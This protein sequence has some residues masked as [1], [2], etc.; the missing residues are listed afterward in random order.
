MNPVFS[1]TGGLFLQGVIHLVPDA[2][3]LFDGLA[4]G[5]DKAGNRHLR[6]LLKMEPMRMVMAD[7]IAAT[8]F[9][10][11][12]LPLAGMDQNDSHFG[13]VA[14]S[15]ADHF[16]GGAKLAGGAVDGG[17][18]AEATELELKNGGRMA[19]GKGNGVQLPEAVTTAQM[20]AE[21][22]ILV[23]EDAAV[24]EFKM[25]GEEGA[26]AK[27]GGRADDGEGRRFN[28]YL[29]GPFPLTA[30]ANRKTLRPAEVFA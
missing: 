18:G 26:D 4:H 5:K 13:L 28:P 9:A 22:G 2:A 1:L 12:R 3:G 6:P 30:A 10:E 15:L 23:P 8:R 29:A 7:A 20:V 14:V 21:F 25:P 19:V 16:G 27:F 17:G 24:S 11:I